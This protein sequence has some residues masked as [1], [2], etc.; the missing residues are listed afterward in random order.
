[1]LGPPQHRH[2]A[3]HPL[4]CALILLLATNSRPFAVSRSSQ[5]VLSDGGCR[6]QVPP[7]RTRIRSASAT[8][9]ISGNS[10]LRR[11]HAGSQAPAETTATMASRMAT[12]SGRTRLAFMA[13]RGELFQVLDLQ[14]VLES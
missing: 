12:R 1:M 4:S 5:R 10:Q 11:C 14:E 13:V 6:W 8:A 9:R 2:T 7:V 3:F